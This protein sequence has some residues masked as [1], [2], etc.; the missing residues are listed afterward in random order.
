MFYTGRI[1]DHISKQEAL[2][3]INNRAPVAIAFRLWE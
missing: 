2:S 1:G 3:Y